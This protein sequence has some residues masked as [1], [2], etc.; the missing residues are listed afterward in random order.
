MKIAFIHPSNPLEES[1]GATYSAN[2]IIKELSERGHDITVYCVNKMED[3][4]N[5]EYET[6]NLVTGDKKYRS[7]TSRLNEEI[8]CRKE[9]FESFDLIYS[10][11]LD[12]ILSL[13]KIRED[14]STKIVVTLN[15]YGG[16]C[17]T[18]TL[19][20]RD[21]HQLLGSFRCLKC[22]KDQTTQ[23][24]KDKGLKQATKLP[25]LA[26][27]RLIRLIR[28]RKASN[29]V[30]NIDRFHSVSEHVKD[31][32]VDAGFPENKIKVTPS[33][34][35]EKFVVEHESDF[36]ESYN[37][38]FIGYLKKHKGAGL[39]VPIIEELNEK[40]EK[41][42]NLTIVGSGPLEEKIERQLENSPASDKVELKGRVPNSELPDVYASHDL[43]VNP[44]KWEEP[45]G[46]VF[47][48][49][50]SAGTPIIS[51]NIENAK[52]LKGV[53]TVEEDKEKF[54]EK[55]AE[56]L[57]KDELEKL[58]TEGREEMNKYM[59]EETVDNIEKSMEEIL[60]KEA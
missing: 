46:R 21:K 3:T 10:Y 17:P 33:I 30:N 29:V 55:L 41:G 13:G 20:Y 7:R 32:Y 31:R 23:E 5:L 8:T 44:V 40:T 6:K 22:I 53:E 60:N 28:I 14:I 56:L 47:L 34:I 9:E 52:A 27:R 18:H 54:A 12:N 39:L 24:L 15:S 49:S 57:D 58:S 48:E 36:E 2:K 26:T 1:T 4:K 25:K 35:N 38:L 51:T 19:M 37:L 42:F 16:I 59:P 43:L 11:R 45:W 50:L